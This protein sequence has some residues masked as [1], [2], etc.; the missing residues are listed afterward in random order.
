M[1]KQE[2]V[3][4]P[5]IDS[6]VHDEF[7]G[8]IDIPAYR[9]GLF[10]KVPVIRLA[11]TPLVPVNHNKFLFELRVQVMGQRHLGCT[12]SSVKPEQH[13]V[14]PVLTPDQDPLVKSADRYFFS[15][16]ILSGIPGNWAVAGRTPR[17]HIPAAAVTPMQ[18][19]TRMTHFFM[20]ECYTI[21]QPWPN[22]IGEK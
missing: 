13:R 14:A 7:N 20:V 5:K 8:V 22:S 4:V 6:E 11:G 16:A 1:P 18:S 3:M 17:K 15:S 19:N 9:H 10:I 2:H 21:N 12:R